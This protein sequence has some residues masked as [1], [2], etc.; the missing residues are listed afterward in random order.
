MKKMKSAPVGV[1][2]KVLAILELLDQSPSGLKLKDIAEQAGINKSTAHRFLSHLESK[3]YLFRDTAGAYMIGP[4]LT[5][6]GA[7]MNSYSTLAKICRGPLENLRAVTGETVNLAVLDGFEVLYVDVLETSHTFRLVSSV[8]TRRHFH[9]TSL[10]KAILANIQDE[11]RR[12]ELFSSIRFEPVT[13]RTITNLPRLK[14]QLAI[15]RKRG[16][17]L[18]DEEAVAGIRCLGVA[19]VDP[20]GEVLG[21]ISVSGPVVRVT[22][23]KLPLFSQEICRAAREI[24]WLLGNNTTKVPRTQQLS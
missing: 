23:A 14:K 8:G 2:D 19:I 4:R 24:T 10:G 16:F 5:K 22:T 7:G 20:D 18:D 12:E 9:C 17:A 13:P 15:I 21:A 1:I 6:L 11:A 3:K